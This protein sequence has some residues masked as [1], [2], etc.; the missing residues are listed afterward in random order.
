MTKPITFKINKPKLG[1]ITGCIADFIFIIGVP[2]RQMNGPLNF[3][4]N[5]HGNT[6]Q[7]VGLNF[8]GTIMG[9]LLAFIVY[10]VV[11]WLAGYIYEK[12]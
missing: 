6:S 11:G 5:L 4:S 10:F 1:L 7:A 9:A 8:T 2:L 12:V 3:L